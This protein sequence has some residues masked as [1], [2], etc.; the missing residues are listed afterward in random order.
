MSLVPAQLTSTSK[1]RKRC[2]P[3]VLHEITHRFILPH[4]SVDKFGFGAKAT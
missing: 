2:D 4:V 1:R 3:W